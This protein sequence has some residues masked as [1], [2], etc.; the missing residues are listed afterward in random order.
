WFTVIDFKDAFFCIPLESKVRAFEWENPQTGRK[1]Q[2]T[3]TVLPQGFKNSPMV[4]GNQLTKELEMWKKENPKGLVLQY[5]DNILLATE[6][7]EKYMELTMSLLNFI[8]QGDYKVSQEKAQIMRQQVIY[9][10]SE[11]TPGQWKLG[12]DRKESIC[13]VPQPATAQDLRAF[14]GMAGLC[15]LWVS[16]YG[17][18][19]KPLNELLKEASE[20]PLTWTPESEHAFSNLKMALMSA[21]AL[22]LPDLTKP[23]ELFVH[24]R[25]HLA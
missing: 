25:Q 21:P 1:N 2:L 18:L 22:G 11:I 9:L 20:G 12:M 16:I 4:F 6:T 24:K 3:W 8:G 10:G 23:F 7:N 14:L 15:R 17:L 5:V 13:Q 19:V